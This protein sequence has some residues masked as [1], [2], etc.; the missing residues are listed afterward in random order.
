[1]KRILITG[2]N[3]YIGISVSNY[4]LQWPDQY[5]V[6]TIDLI[7]GTWREKSF[8]PYD[9]VYHV[10]G[11]AHADVNKL[12]NECKEKYFSVNTDLAIETA[13][14]AKADG[15]VQF[16]FMS[17][18]CVYGNS[19]PIGKQKMITRETPPSPANCYGNSKLK[20]EWGIIPLQNET[21]NVV[22]L[23]PPMIYGKNCKGNYQSLVKLALMLPVFPKIENRRSMLYIGNFIE[24]VRLMIENEERGTFWP[25]NKE[26]SNTSEII[27][28]IAEAHGKKLLLIKGFKWVIKLLSFYKKNLTKAFGELTYEQNMSKYKTEY[29][30]FSPSESIRLTEDDNG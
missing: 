14:K 29:C 16:I 4:L 2:A 6:D 5:A 11:I 27:E 30:R 26:Y 19:S 28:M 18:A 10:A 1:M 9:V 3:S 24:F 21:F 22:I 25:Q 17:S 20:A 8:S 13:K 7:D 23:R 12:T 15:V